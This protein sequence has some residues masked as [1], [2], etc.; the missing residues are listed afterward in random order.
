MLQ[1]LD[2]LKEY[3]A[4]C[5]TGSSNKYAEFSVNID[6]VFHVDS[7][8]TSQ[9]YEVQGNEDMAIYMLQTILVRGKKFRLFF[10]NGCGDM[11]VR[12]SAVDFLEKL[13]LAK[14][15]VKG[16]LVLS[17]VA[18]QQSICQYGRYKITL[19]LHNGTEVD[20]CGICID[21]ITSTFPT[22]P[23]DQ[24]EKDIKQDY[25][26]K[27]GD[28]SNLP[29]L[30]PCV[31]GDTDIMLGIQYLKYFP[32]EI[33]RMENGLA[34][35]ESPFMSYD[36][37][38]G[39]VGGPHKSFNLLHKNLSNHVDFNAYFSQT[40]PDS[41]SYFR[42]N[43]DTGILDVP[44]SKIFYDVTI[45]TTAKIST[46]KNLAGGVTYDEFVANSED[47]TNET[48][49]T[50]NFANKRVPKI[51]KRFE[52]V[53]K[54]GT[55]LS[56]RCVKCRGCSNCKK[57]AKIESISLQEEME[58]GIINNS[59]TVNL[60]VQYTSAFLP[61]LCDPTKKLVDNYSISEKIYFN[62]IK[63][64][65]SKSS[66]DK[67]EVVDALKKLINLG[68]ISKYESLSEEEKCLIDNSPVRYYIPW[69]AVW[70]SNSLSTP[71]RPVFNASC[72]TKTGYSLNDLLP[73]GKNSLNKLG[74]IFIRWLIYTCA[75]HSDIQKMYN[76]IRLVP[77]HWCYQLCLF[78]DNLNINVKPLVHVIKTLIYG[79]RSSGNQAEKAVRDTGDLNKGEYPRANEIIQDDLYMDDCLSGQQSYEL[80]KVVTDSLQM[81]LNMGGFHLKGITFSGFDP[82]THLCNVMMI[83]PL[84]SQD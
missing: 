83:N 63:R 36:K 47:F 43:L 40:I 78:E 53:E 1:N 37:S 48:Y 51:V 24:V 25:L 58:Q 62:Q 12:K 76:T 13:G 19:P 50:R 26:S 80:G 22:F 35:F 38:R 14:N 31:G 3:K 27:G 79:V 73:M 54:A 17:G 42:Q 60:M 28:L 64:L 77:E 56:Y 32:K 29:K 55:E 33:H 34:L 66:T 67:N 21:T 46:N 84:M 81:V 39:T 18:E 68:F 70:N 72:P 11:V 20:L 69:T 23:L 57:S 16:P 8:L 6:N 65:D 75:F 9:S 7:H 59:V 71:C 15:I 5:I 61:F 4:K 52:E 10:D 2:L 74:Q 41:Q 45:G 82:P 44:S 30:P 49:V